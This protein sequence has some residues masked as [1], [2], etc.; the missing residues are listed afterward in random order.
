VSLP[1]TEIQSLS[2]S[3]L[4][5]LFV[6]DATVL[7]GSTYYFHAGTN[8]LAS[9]I[10]WNGV[11]YTAFPIK[12][13]GFEWTSK[14]TLPRPKLTVS[15]IDGVVGAL[16]H[17]LNDLVGAKVTLKRTFAKYLDAVNFPGGYNPTADP[18]AAYTDEPW[19]VERK[20]LE[21]KETLEFELCAP[22][23]VV[24]ATIP[25]RRITA[26]IC[27]WVYKGTECGYTGAKATCEKRLTSSNG[28]GGCKEHF[29]VT[30]GSISLSSTITANTYTRTVGSFISDGFQ[31]GQTVY[32]NGF[33]NTANNG[34]HV[35]TNVA[36]LVLTVA[37]AL[38]TETASTGRSITS[39]PDLPLGCFPGTSK[40]R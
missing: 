1:L 14:G 32:V 21:T 33:T 5:E 19:V 28:D 35:V 34:A 13:D 39:N 7:G 3:A 17:S 31:T 16:V 29:V 37:E 10:V 22:M 12:A 6:L 24:N 25:K 36:A 15:N 4:I 26:N 8:G 30:T 9:N 38:S 23:D 11:T 27:G 2:P 40:V 20:T 18:T